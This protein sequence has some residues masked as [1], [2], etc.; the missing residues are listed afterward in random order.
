LGIIEVVPENN[1]IK[2]SEKKSVNPV[3][4]FISGGFGGVCTVVAGH[5]L[6]TI[7]VLIKYV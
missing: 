2:M 4:Y 5:P 3:K 1:C 6:D 7:K